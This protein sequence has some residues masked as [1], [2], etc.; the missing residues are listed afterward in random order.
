MLL[1]KT[2]WG[3]R[4]VLSFSASPICQIVAA[5]QQLSHLYEALTFGEKR[6]ACGKTSNIHF[7]DDFA[8]CR[9]EDGKSIEQKASKNRIGQKYNLAN[10]TMN[11]DKCC[12]KGARA[13]QSMTD[14]ELKMSLSNLKTFPA[15]IASKECA[16]KRTKWV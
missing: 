11:T 15:S 8:R 10:E 7:G 6:T 12:K 16:L 3:E 13:N 5:L 14:R 4:H 9:L 2:L 1:V